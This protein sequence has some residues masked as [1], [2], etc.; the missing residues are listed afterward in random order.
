MP[1]YALPGREEIVHRTGSG[2]GFLGHMV[3]T[4]GKWY[5]AS[6]AIAYAPT[7]KAVYPGA[8]EAHGR[9]TQGQHR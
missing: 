3:T 8:E 5:L 1:L 2:M 7:E 6:Q 4:H 9:P